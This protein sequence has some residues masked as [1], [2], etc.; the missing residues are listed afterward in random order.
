ME[1]KTPGLNEEQW[2]R[3]RKDVKDILDRLFKVRR[4]MKQKLLPKKEMKYLE[5]AIDYIEKF[6]AHAEDGIFKYSGPKDTNIWYP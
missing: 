5:K 4:T 3:C 6:R 1:N 2:K